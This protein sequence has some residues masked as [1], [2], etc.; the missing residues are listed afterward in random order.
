MLGAVAPAWIH[1]GPLCDVAQCLP[2]TRL[3]PSISNE[4]QG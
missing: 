4:A 1:K 3:N 2:S